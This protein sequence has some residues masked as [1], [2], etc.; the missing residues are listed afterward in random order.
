MSRYAMT[1]R[2][3]LMIMGLYDPYSLFSNVQSELSEHLREAMSCVVNS[4]GVFVFAQIYIDL[5]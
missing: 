4:N 3:H 1:C 5:I 2:T